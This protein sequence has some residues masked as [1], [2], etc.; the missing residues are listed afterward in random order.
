M[1]AYKK[2]WSSFPCGPDSTG[3]PTVAAT[4]V[5]IN[6]LIDNILLSGIVQTDTPNQAIPA[7]W[8]ALDDINGKFV[9]FAL[10]DARQSLEP[11]TFRL[12]FYYGAVDYRVPAGSY[13]NGV[14]IQVSVN[15][16]SL[17]SFIDA[18]PRGRYTPYNS[19]IAGYGLPSTIG[20]CVCY[21]SGDLFYIVYGI[22][23]RGNSSTG[24]DGGLRQSALNLFIKRVPGGAVVLIKNQSLRLS[25]YNS[26]S[27]SLRMND[28]VNGFILK[29]DSVRTITDTFVSDLNHKSMLP[30]NEDRLASLSG[31][32]L[33]APTYCL[34]ANNAVI[35]NDDVL[36]THYTSVPEMGEIDVVTESGTSK[37]ISLGPWSCAAPDSN[38]GHRAIHLYRFDD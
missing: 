30:G 14:S 27:T 3:A 21:Y 5:W 25:P 19:P 17:S 12:T 33:V 28:L 38:I 35:V 32:I 26:G 6:D 22:G 31:E 13:S 8:V 9:E 18:F 24:A 1:A 11:I 29:E 37:F 20:N 4:I 7:S 2:K 15:F 10:T 36:V 16:K 23:A 34:D